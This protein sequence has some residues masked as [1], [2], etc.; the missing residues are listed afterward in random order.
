[1]NSKF[2]IDGCYELEITSDGTLNEAGNQANARAF[3]KGNI[4]VMLHYTPMCVAQFIPNS[5]GSPDKWGPTC[6]E[7][8]TVTR[9]ALFLKR[10]QARAIASALLNAVS[11]AGE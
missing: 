4:G 5:D 10:N 3:S 1:M 11:E 7:P 8:S 9:A 2:K 6:D